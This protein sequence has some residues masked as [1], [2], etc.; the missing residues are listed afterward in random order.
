MSETERI[1]YVVMKRWTFAI[2]RVTVVKETE[3]SWLLKPQVHSPRCAEYATIAG[4]AYSYPSLRHPKPGNLFFSR[5]EAVQFAAEY[6]SGQ[7]RALHLKIE[8]LDALEEEL[9]SVQEVTP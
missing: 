2:V 8:A 9:A 7:I 4:H 3:K 6:L 1:A 5:E